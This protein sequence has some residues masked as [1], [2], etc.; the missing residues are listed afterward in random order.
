MKY[1]KWI[2]NNTHLLTN[3]LAIV[4]GATGTIGKEVVNYLLQLKNI[5]FLNIEKIQKSIWILIFN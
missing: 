1:D 4:V 3:Q 5:V 2:K